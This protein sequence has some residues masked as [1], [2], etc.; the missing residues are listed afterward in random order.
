MTLPS[1]SLEYRSG[2]SDKVY[3]AAITPSGGGYVVTFSYGRRGASLTHGTK[4]PSPVDL[5]KAEKVFNQITSE[6]VRKGYTPV[7]GAPAAVA[8]VA[9]SRANCDSGV[10]FQ[11]LTPVDSDADLDALIAD[12]AFVCQAK[13]DGERRGLVLEDGQI[14]ATQRAGLIVTVSPDIA[15]ALAPVIQ[16]ITGRTVID[17]EDLG[18]TYAAF[19][20]LELNG[21]DLRDQPF[22]E[23]YRLLAQLCE[24]VEANIT[25]LPVYIGPEAKRHLLSRVIETGGEGIVLKRASAP[26]EPGRPNS[27]G[28]Q[29]KWKLYSEATLE[30]GASAREG[31]RSVVLLAADGERR[32]EVGNV[33]IPA[34]ADVPAEGS[35]VEVRYLYRYSGGSL[36]Q[37]A[38]KSARPD[39][40][41]PDQLS[42]LRLK[43]EQA[44][45]AA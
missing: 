30:V 21:R 33:T 9:E 26:Y 10:R 12:P 22:C 25:V 20:L 36:F 2:G 35:F 13:A 6:K 31:K 4:T 32:V 28:D 14:T 16:R 11:L 43:P 37:P 39:K 38:F 5:P 45:L 17:G 3:N 42:C 7:D 44:V 18:S 40:T 8:A 15:A 1:V 29:R 41:E 34:N 27:G 24:G 19:D 23:R